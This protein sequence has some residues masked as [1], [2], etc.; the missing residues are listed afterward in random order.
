M[1]SIINPKGWIRGYSQPN[2]MIDAD[3]IL[4]HA[5]IKLNISDH[6]VILYYQFRYIMFKSAYAKSSF[7][8]IVFS[9]ILLLIA[10]S[11]LICSQCFSARI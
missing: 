5:N 2:I 7:I 4:L 3:R 6:L 9:I 8:I 10:Y 1:L 11:N